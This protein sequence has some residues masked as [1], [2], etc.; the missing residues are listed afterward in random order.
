MRWAILLSLASTAVGCLAPP[1]RGLPLYSAG[2]A[3]V[4]SGQVATLD[5]Q[6]PFPSTPG[7]VRTFIQSVD[8]RDV[9]TLASPFELL[10]GCHVVETAPHWASTRARFIY[11]SGPTGTQIF[12]IRMRAGHAYTVVEKWSSP[13]G[14]LVTISVYAVE[15]D[16]VG[17]QTA[18]ISAAAND[19][20]VQAC[21]AWTPPTS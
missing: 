16:L 14:P 9:A 13:L 12:P 19:A 1:E 17:G 15:R 8:G 2:S 21:R 7:A 4:P 6:V 5:V 20:D 3:A 11:S 10:P 18:E